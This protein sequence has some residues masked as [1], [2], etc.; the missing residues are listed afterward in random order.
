[1]RFGHRAIVDPVL[2]H[3]GDLMK[4]KTEPLR[5]IFL[6]AEIPYRK[7]PSCA[8]FPKN[9]DMEG[10]IHYYSCIVVLGNELD[11]FAETKQENCATAVKNVLRY[12][13]HD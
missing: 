10:H 5:S 4:K 9:N 7:H 1:M 6:P 12:S 2:L 3:I 11:T 13:I 8:S